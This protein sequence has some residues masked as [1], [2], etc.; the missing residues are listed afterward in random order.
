MGRVGRDTVVGLAREVL[1][2]LK[3]RRDEG[4]RT[5]TVVRGQTG[6]HRLEERLEELGVFNERGW[7]DGHQRKERRVR[8]DVS[9]E[10]V[11]QSRSDLALEVLLGSSNSPGLRDLFEEADEAIEEGK[12]AV[13]V[14]LVEELD[15]VGDVLVEVLFDVHLALVGK[16][17]HQEVLGLSDQWGL[18]IEFPEVCSHD[19]VVSWQQLEV[20]LFGEAVCECDLRS[21]KDH[22]RS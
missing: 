14:G 10:G 4:I 1:D 5:E 16:S 13:G 2:D 6:P 17:G 3:E 8:S 7:K 18:L 12:E 21:M 19:F 15:K 22:Q 9:V 11:T 20:R